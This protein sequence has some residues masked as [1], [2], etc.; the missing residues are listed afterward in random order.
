MLD[1]FRFF[2]NIFSFFFAFLPGSIKVGSTGRNSI[3]S[4]MQHRLSQ[5]YAYVSIIDSSDSIVFNLVSISAIY[6]ARDTEFGMKV[7]VSCLQ[8]K[9]CSNLACLLEGK[10]SSTRRKRHLSRKI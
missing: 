6:N 4:S 5:R 7:S 3:P 8:I 2:L 10:R 9:F 1:S